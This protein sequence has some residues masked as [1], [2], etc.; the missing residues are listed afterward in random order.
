MPKIFFELVLIFMLR[1]LFKK[2]ATMP[3]FHFSAAQRLWNI[4]CADSCCGV[5]FVVWALWIRHYRYFYFFKVDLFKNVN[6]F[7][8]FIYCKLTKASFTKKIND[9]DSFRNWC[10]YSWF[11][12]YRFLFHSN[13]REGNLSVRNFFKIFLG[14][15]NSNARACLILFQFL[16]IYFPP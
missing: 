15:V 10:L 2:W 8:Y 11:R 16:F 6:K 9:F 5:G 14:F 12:S 4:C 13:F 3:H 7:S 1:R